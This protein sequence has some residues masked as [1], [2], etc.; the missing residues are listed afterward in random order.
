MELE[1]KQLHE[2]M[3]IAG[4]GS[5]VADN[6]TSAFTTNMELQSSVSA[7]SLLNFRC[8]TDI[9]SYYHQQQQMQSS[10]PYNIGINSSCFNFNYNQFFSTYQQASSTATTTP[11]TLEPRAI[12]YHSSASLYDATAHMFTDNNSDEHLTVTN[13]I[14]ESYDDKDREQQQ[15]QDECAEDENEVTL[16]TVKDFADLLEASEFDDE[17]NKVDNNSEASNKSTDDDSVESQQREIDGE[18]VADEEALN[19]ESES[20]DD[21]GEITVVEAVTA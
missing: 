13:E 2:Q 20:S 7:D 4:I 19:A 1:K 15:Q 21:L 17:P 14:D 11:F 6:L 9:Q 3:S 18:V 5:G 8:A 16:T 12:D 10:S